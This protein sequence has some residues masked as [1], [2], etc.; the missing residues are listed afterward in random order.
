MEENL[1]SIATDWKLQVDL[2][3][4]LIFPQEISTTNLRPDMVL[5]STE[6]RVVYIIELTV[7]WET[8]VDEAFER[9]RNKY[10]QLSDE[11][12]SRG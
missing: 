10:S 8:A 3:Y 2:E 7:P 5:W 12:N 6:K 1:L 9:K 4:R 11:A